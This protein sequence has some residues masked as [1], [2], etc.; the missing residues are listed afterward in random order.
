MK[1]LSEILDL[2]RTN[3]QQKKTQYSCVSSKSSSKDAFNIVVSG[4]AP[5]L[6]TGCFQGTI[7]N[8]PKFH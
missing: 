4:L 5:F 2:V 1:A 8:L 7:C 6:V 3:K